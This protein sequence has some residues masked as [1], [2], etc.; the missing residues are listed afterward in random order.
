MN[1]RE[2]NQE[3]LEYIRDISAG[4][5]RPIAVSDDGLWF[6]VWYP[7]IFGRRV[8]IFQRGGDMLCDYCC[9]DDEIILAIVAAAIR[10]LMETHP[11][12]GANPHEV[13][14]VLP[15]WRVRPVNKDPECWN[16]LMTLGFGPNGP[17]AVQDII[18]RVA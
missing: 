18:T 15:P 9:G 7:M 12:D 17:R 5:Y 14:I 10:G 13:G 2:F 16:A 3:E 11:S 6:I 8:G 1:L 4:E